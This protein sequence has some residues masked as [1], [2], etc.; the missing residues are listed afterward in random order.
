[1]KPIGLIGGMS[2]ESTISYYEAMNRLVRKQ[3]GGLH[4]LPVYM[5][6]VDFAPFARMQKEGQ[7]AEIGRQL[8]REARRLEQ[9]GAKAIVLATNTMHAVAG[10]ISKDLSIPFLHIGDAAARKISSEGLNTVGL[11]GTGFTMEQ[12]FYHDRLRAHGIGTLIPS[13]EDRTFIHDAIFTELCMGVLN[14]DTKQRFLV[15]MD[16]LRQ[17]GA[18]GIVLG[19][20]EIPLLINAEDTDMP[21]FNTPEIHAEAAVAFA[22]ADPS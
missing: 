3:I 15:I 5:A 13:D 1:M 4:S 12:P 18:Q 14:Q 17:K 7:W 2:W 21:L 8:N 10:D 11:L 22:T 9:A 20:T 16:R 6:S 19:C